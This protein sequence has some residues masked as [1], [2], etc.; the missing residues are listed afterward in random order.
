MAIKIIESRAIMNIADE[1]TRAIFALSDIYTENE[2]RRWFFSS[3]PLLGNQ[4][5]A[6]LIKEGRAEEVRAA[7]S[8]L[9]SYG[10]AQPY[11]SSGTGASD[12]LA[13]S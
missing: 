6:K 13:G 4:I 8:Q 11:E 7:I 3:Q 2:V 9:N 12:K 5:P 1:L 10:C